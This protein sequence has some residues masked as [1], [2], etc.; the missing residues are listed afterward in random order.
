MSRNQAP[1]FFWYDD[2]YYG[3]LLALGRNGLRLFGVFAGDRLVAAAMAVVNGKAA[4]YHLGAS[5]MEF[6]KQGA[7]NLSLFQMSKDLMRSGVAFVNMTGGR[8]TSPDDP[9]L[10]FKRSNATGTLPF[11]IGKRIVDPD[12]YRAVGEAWRRATGRDPD[13]AKIIF[14]RP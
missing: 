13:A 5:L 12:A 10:L 9:L 2:A 3:K 6:A 7:G 4:L 11:H 14:W 8:T 1:E